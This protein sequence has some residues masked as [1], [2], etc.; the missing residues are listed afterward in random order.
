MKISTYYFLLSCALVVST[1]GFG[2]YGY[3][4]QSTIM[5]S[6]HKLMQNSKASA[7][8][9]NDVIILGAPLANISYM[10]PAGLQ[11]GTAAGTLN[12][13]TRNNITQTWSVYDYVRPSD[14]APND[15]FGCS[16]GATSENLIVG[17][18][19]DDDNGS[20]SGSAFIYDRDAFT[21]DHFNFEPT[22]KLVASDAAPSDF[23]GT[24]V[25]ISNDWALVGA[26][27]NDDSFSSSGSAYL[28]Q[29][30]EGGSNNWGQVKKLLAPDAA[31]N[32]FFGQEVKISDT[33][34][35]VSSPGAQ[36]IYI[37]NQNAG[38]PN[39]WGH[40][41][42]ITPSIP[43]SN[44]GQ[45]ISVLNDFLVVGTDAERA[46]VYDVN[47]GG[48]NNWG[49]VQVLSPDPGEAGQYF[50]RSVSINK[51]EA[52]STLN[53][54][55]GARRM[56]HKGNDSGAVYWFQRNNSDPL[57]KKRMISASDVGAAMEFGYSVLATD[58]DL[59]IGRYDADGDVRH[60]TA[61]SSTGTVAPEIAGLTNEYEMPDYL[62]TKVFNQATVQ[63]SDHTNLEISLRL[64]N[65]SI[66]TLGSP[67]VLKSSGLYYYTGTRDQVNTALQ[68]VLFTPTNNLVGLE[69]YTLSDLIVKLDDFINNPFLDTVSFKSNSTN[70]PPQVTD[71]T[72]DLYL[73]RPIGTVIA[74]LNATDPDPGQTLSF[75]IASGNPDN[76]F[77]ISSTG[78][79]TLI[80]P[81][82]WEVHGTSFELEVRATDSYATDP[83]FV[84]GTATILLRDSVLHNRKTAMAYEGQSPAGLYFGKFTAISDEF[85]VIANTGH[86]SAAYGLVTPK[87]YLYN[88]IDGALSFSKILHQP[89]EMS[90]YGDILAMNNEWLFVGE[91]YNDLVATNAGAVAVFNRHQGGINNWGFVKNITIPGMSSNSLFGYG[92]KVANDR[93][94]VSAR[95]ADTGKG[96]NSGAVYVFLKDQGGMNQWGLE[97][98]IIPNELGSSDNFGEHLSLS[99][100]GNTLAV[101]ASLDD[102]NGSNTGATYI[103]KKNDDGDFIQSQ[104]ISNPPGSTGSYIKVSVQDSVL[105]LG[106]T[107]NNSLG[108]I[109]EMNDDGNFELSISIPY[110]Y[111]YLQ[112]FL[113]T[114]ALNNNQVVIATDLEFQVWQKGWPQNS[115]G[116]IQQLIQ[117][118]NLVNTESIAIGGGKVLVGNKG[119]YT[120]YPSETYP[121]VPS[122]AYLFDLRPP[123]QNEALNSNAVLSV[124][125]LDGERLQETLVPVKISH[126]DDLGGLQLSLHWN[127]GILEFIGI[128]DFNLPGLNENSFALNHI[129]DGYLTLA[130]L[131]PDLLGF[132]SLEDVTIF[133]IR[134]RPIGNY[135]D[136]TPITVDNIPTPVMAVD[137]NLSN[138]TVEIVQG[139]FTINNNQTING[140]TY[141]ISGNP[142]EET[143]ITIDDS[144]GVISALQLTNDEGAYAIPLILNDTANVLTITPTKAELPVN[145]DLVDVA[146]VASIRRHILHVETITSP[147]QLI[148]ADV[149]NDGNI[150]LIDMVDLQSVIIGKT[151]QFL[152]GN[153]WA[154]IPETY[155]IVDGQVP[156]GYPQIVI[157][158]LDVNIPEEIN[159]IGIRI[160][161]VTMNSAD[162]AK[163]SNPAA[164]FEYSKPILQVDGRYLVNVKST[165]IKNIAALQ[166]TVGW[167]VHDWEFSEFQ[168]QH[169]T[170]V[171][172]G[173][174]KIADGK[175]AVAWD[176]TQGSSLI[177]PQ[178]TTV[179]SIILTKKSLSLLAED[180]ITF[181]DQVSKKKA[182][183]SELKNLPLN[184]VYSPEADEV[185]PDT[186]FYPNPLRN[187]IVSIE[188]NSENSGIGTFLIISSDG[189][190]EQRETVSI[191]KGYNV[192]NFDGIR[193][194]RKGVYVFSLITGTRTIRS[195]MVKP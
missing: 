52:T 32:N 33:I 157:V 24:S 119:Y 102:D 140:T 114:Q 68:N 139:S 113:H 62:S 124:D 64:T 40:V 154:F 80:N 79:I 84:T 171:A 168:S 10:M 160:G 49:E 8:A 121:Q 63:D 134:F 151:N 108:E 186:R 177:F 96:N 69:Y 131:D 90:Y 188:F 35:F 93:L 47:L 132:T 15:N 176:H 105:I 21:P 112:D 5:T 190:L 82:N 18:R 38:G 128:E 116:V 23:F 1:V 147:Y 189:K 164:V 193:T 81:I 36:K 26:Y 179:F 85:A 159:F 77:S 91:P 163:V 28:F 34:A 16:V 152:S 20:S 87:I 88:L 48:I 65:P 180:V 31:S 98:T 109:Y 175:L 3:L 55:V 192:L 187:D 29:R 162:G 144:D 50:G 17:M 103:F 135:G 74:H 153:E 167:N 127:P 75:S 145:L 149:V 44:F 76:L 7:A 51:N 58:N 12:Y 56:N 174:S 43:S 95:S 123:T 106:I 60:Y 97:Q 141:G 170:S 111:K 30:N 70:E 115:W 172:L 178:N 14:S 138:P 150:N 6:D 129:Q 110:T 122:W 25:S 11:G 191:K 46:F 194:L 41:K 66:G 158:P 169:M 78:N 120:D 9:C 94:I 92:V 27:G 156:V 182:F 184:F 155:E 117:Q 71:L 148:A 143:N 45:Y 53:I 83:K 72:V 142:L 183:N 185:D 125:H 39:N 130:W 89:A 100:T 133:N 104:K 42:T 126:V 99:N 4:E 2:Q 181:D 195:L 146:D 13:Y 137:I 118:N 61:A 166:F 19:G 59:F 161:D 22:K 173:K 57:A 37:F 136:V 107:K 101:T 73:D 165:G 67:F 54:F 86:Y